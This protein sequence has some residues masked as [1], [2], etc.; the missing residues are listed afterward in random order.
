MVL[1]VLVAAARADEDGSDDDEVRLAAGAIRLAPEDPQLMRPAAR[2]ARQFHDAARSALRRGD[3]VEA[4]SLQ[5]RAFG[6]NPADAEIVGSLAWLRLKQS[7][8]HPE[9]A[10]R[11]ALHALTLHD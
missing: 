4:V 8:N 7:S 1:R 2:E 9:A 3:F 5:T 6:A 10:R 11:L